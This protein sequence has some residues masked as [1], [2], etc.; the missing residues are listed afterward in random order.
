M[1]MLMQL[2]LVFENHLVKE[3]AHLTEGTSFFNSYV[4]VEE[5]HEKVFHHIQK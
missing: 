2:L 3:V 5:E 1:Q 4:Q